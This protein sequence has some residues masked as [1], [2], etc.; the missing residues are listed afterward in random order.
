VLLVLPRKSLR[1]TALAAFIL[2]FALTGLAA[3]NGGSVGTQQ[4][5][6]AQV[7]GTPSGS[8]NIIVTG[9]SKNITASSTFTLVVK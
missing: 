2:V 5:P 4:L 7:P 8:Y 9:T 1:R 3:C 6:P